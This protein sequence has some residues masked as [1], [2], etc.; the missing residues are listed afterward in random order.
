[1]QLRSC[2]MVMNLPVCVLQMR[3]A[4]RNLTF[5]VNDKRGTL[6]G[7]VLIL[8][9][10]HNPYRDCIHSISPFNAR[11]NVVRV[12][13]TPEQ[14]EYHT[15]QQQRHKDTSTHKPPSRP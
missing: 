10:R 4:G 5:D 13:S 11:H 2:E 3:M 8:L 6:Q 14:Q 1:M 7:G 12:P 9:E 15:P